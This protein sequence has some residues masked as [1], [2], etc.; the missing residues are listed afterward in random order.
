MLVYTTNPGFK[1]IVV[2]YKVVL[3]NNSL[4][5]MFTIFFNCCYTYSVGA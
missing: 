2:H 1:E 5:K 3:I 4:F